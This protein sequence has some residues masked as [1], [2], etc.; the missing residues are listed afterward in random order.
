MLSKEVSS[1]EKHSSSL[2]MVD[3][4]QTTKELACSEG[5]IELSK[6]LCIILLF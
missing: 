3:W 6:T 2:V 4:L 5:I 1:L